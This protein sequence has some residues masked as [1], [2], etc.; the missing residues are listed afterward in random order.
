MKSMVFRYSKEELDPHFRYNPDTGQLFRF[1]N[2]KNEWLEQTHVCPR[3]GY[4]KTRG[5]AGFKGAANVNAQ[6]VIACLLGYPDAIPD[7]ENGI[8]TDNRLSNLRF[9]DQSENCKN[10]SMRSDNTSGHTGVSF[11]KRDQKWY[12]NISI[13]KKQKHIG[14][15]DSFEEAVKTRKAA[16]R[17]YGYHKNHGR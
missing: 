16:E 2:K 17:L 8:K 10:L 4:I 1:N 6:R 13:N 7:H 5:P 14:S 9:V 12:V 15:F 11:H 3:R